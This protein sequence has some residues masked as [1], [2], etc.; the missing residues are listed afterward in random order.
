MNFCFLSE[1]VERENDFRQQIDVRR[2]QMDAQL[3]LM[4]ASNL[5][6]E[7]SDVNKMVQLV[8]NCLSFICL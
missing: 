5:G 2:Q 3:R 1:M 8:K 6:W 4:D 7:E